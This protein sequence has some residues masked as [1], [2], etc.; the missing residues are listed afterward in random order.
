IP[1]NQPEAHP[2]AAPNKG[3]RRGLPLLPYRQTQE[4]GYR[5]GFHNTHSAPAPGVLSVGYIGTRN[6]GSRFFLACAKGTEIH[7]ISARTRAH[8][9]VTSKKVNIIILI[10]YRAN[11]MNR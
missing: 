2:A 8:F 3:F 5:D 6:Q 1:G 7:S 4:D 11:G 10:C 9:R